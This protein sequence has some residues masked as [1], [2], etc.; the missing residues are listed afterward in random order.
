[1]LKLFVI[2]ISCAVVFEDSHGIMV[3]PTPS[4]TSSSKST[5]APKQSNSAMLSVHSLASKSENKN[6][7]TSALKSSHPATPS[8]VTSTAK[9]SSA[10]TRSIISPSSTIAPKPTSSPTLIPTT[11]PKPTTPPP[12]YG[13]F[14]LEENGTF[15]LLAEFVAAIT[16]HYKKTNDTKP[17]MVVQY[18]NRTTRDDVSVKGDC[19][20]GKTSSR[21]VLS[22]PKKKPLYELTMMFEELVAVSANS[23]KTMWEMSMIAFKATVKGNGA[24]LNFSGNDTYVISKYNSSKDFGKPE[25]G[26]YYKCKATKRMQLG[27]DLGAKFKVDSS[28]SDLKLEPFANSTDGS[29]VNGTYTECPEDRPKS[30]PSPSPT[31]SK[32]NDIVP[33]AVGCA[34]AGLVLIV[35]IAYVIGRRKSHSGYE[36]V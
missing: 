4:P 22:W 5:T 16:V 25:L 27:N 3:S 24:F 32:N 23:N 2:F 1:M 17:G 18:L 34:L 8:V 33:I 13:K 12:T 14:S 28:F 36:K 30:S 26:S 21:L 6:Q 29:F 7:T 10:A 19:G 9:A 35:L 11:T 31:K 15:C 20:I